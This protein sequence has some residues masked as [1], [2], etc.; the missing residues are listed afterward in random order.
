M[1]PKASTKLPP[2]LAAV[3]PGVRYEPDE[4]PK[5]KHHWEKDEPGFVEQRRD[6][7]LIKIGKCPKSLTNSSAEL[8]LRKGVGF[9]PPGWREV[10][11]ER[12]YV[13]HRG[14]VYRATV[15][16]ANTPSYHG[17]PEL[18]EKFPRHRELRDAVLKLAQEEGEPFY[19]QVKKWL[20]AKS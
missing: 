15:T 16:N 18:P 10:R 9:N 8:L 17:F 5:R 6:G 7:Q 12:I 1:A 13:V 14:T 2:C 19:S 20:S 4:K 3:P 11:P